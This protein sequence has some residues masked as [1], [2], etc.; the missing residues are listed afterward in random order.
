MHEEHSSSRFPFTRRELLAKSG[1][2]AAGLAMLGLAA[3]ADDTRNSPVRIGSGEFTYEL[4]E[5]WGKLPPGMTYGWGCGVVVDSK[6]RVYVHTRS[7]QCVVVFDRN[8]K[9]LTDWGAEMMGV[10][11]GL[12][13]SREGKDEFLFF[14]TNTPGDTVTKTDL[15]GKPLLQIGNV[16]EESSASIKFKFQ[17]PTDVAIAPNGD[18]YVCEGYGSQLIHRFTRAGKH[19]QTIGGPGNA[20]DKFNI[21]HGIWVDTRK[22]EPEIYIADRANNRLCVYTM[23]LQLRRL[24]Y[25]DVRNPC[26][27]YTQKGRMFVPDLDHRV[28]VLDAHDQVL[29]QLGDGRGKDKT[30]DPAVFRA[31]HAL[32]LDSH[33]DLY[34]V[35]WVETGRLRKFRH[36]PQRA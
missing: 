7:K 24:L 31:P 32:V 12:Y 5:G 2:A 30:D 14:T 28:T 13:W 10:A 6:D 19:L 21:C 20:P 11:H 18:I 22:P 4:V 26:C 34:V 9:I 16:P 17:N 25:G 23:D 36:T 15:N 35:E 27:F 29:A 8:G 3:E 33:G 1:V